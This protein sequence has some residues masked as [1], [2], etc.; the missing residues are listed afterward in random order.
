MIGHLPGV[1]VWGPPTSTVDWC[2]ANYA[3]SR[4]VCE[5]FNTLSSLAM[6]IAGVSGAL[7]HRRV[8][9]RWML[10]GFGCL[11]VVGLGSVAFHGTLKFEFQLLDE[12]PMLYL[13]T[14][15]VYLLLEPGPTNRLGRWLPVALLSYAFLA[16]ISDAFTRGRFQFFAFQITFGALELFCLLRIGL[17]SWEGPN[18][19]V[20]PLFKVGLALYLSGILFWFVDL[21]FCAWLNVQLPEVGLVNPQ[22][23][24]WWHLFVS[25]GFY[26]LLLVVAFDRLQRRGL[27]PVVNSRW[28][29]VPVV[30]LTS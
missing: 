16:T 1:G 5:F 25:G 15:M 3:V 20:R 22:L 12:L 8:F 17:L 9:D 26:L 28:G 27:N 13:V 6:V 4:F 10:A 29:V 2:E 30:R 23:H 11:G 24:A 14:M 18:R 7:A 19:P 21:R